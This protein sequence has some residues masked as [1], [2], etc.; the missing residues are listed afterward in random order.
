MKRKRRRR[1][2]RRWG[3]YTCKNETTGQ[4]VCVIARWLADV[5]V[6]TAQTQRL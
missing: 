2:R 1:G 4:L 5:Q 6:S 3:K